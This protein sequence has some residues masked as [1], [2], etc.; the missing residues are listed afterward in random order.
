VRVVRKGRRVSRRQ[1]LE[2]RYLQ[3]LERRANH[4][5]KVVANWHGRPGGDSYSRSELAAL[6]WAISIARMHVEN[7]R[8][9]TA[10]G[11][12]G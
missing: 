8:V 1:S 11:P 12:D 3:R 9:E 6:E 4:L 5:R 10:G 7:D 2:R